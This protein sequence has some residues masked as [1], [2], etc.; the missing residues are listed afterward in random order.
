MINK[1]IWKAGAL[2]AAATLAFAVFAFRIEEWSKGF[3]SEFLVYGQTGGTTG[4]GGTSGPEVAAVTR[5]IPHIP[6]GSFDGNIS[7]YVSVI[8]IFNPGAA[9]IS[10][11]GTFYNTD[12]TDS[13]LS[14][15]RTS[16]TGT[17]SFTRT[18]SSV[19]VEANGVLVLTADTAPAYVANWARITATGNAVISSYFELRDGATSALYNRTGIASSP[20]DRQAFAIPRVA[21]VARNLDVGFALL[22]TG[23]TSANI[24]GTL[25]G[26]RGTPMAVCTI[27]M[28][29]RTQRA[30]FARSFFSDATCSTRLGT[31]AAGT[32]FGTI[33]FSSTSRQFAAAALAIEGANLSSFP[34]ES[35]Q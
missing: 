29:A 11:T 20:E 22:N 19:A 8:Q 31:E 10:V 30:V 18:F 15:S 6:V 26:A 12:G 32:N 25:R 28:P 33:V 21:D 5:I 1:R 13:T 2:A 9:A 4:G 35:I 7:R 27:T 23:A 24:T 16:A 3:D 34:I 14:I 17:E